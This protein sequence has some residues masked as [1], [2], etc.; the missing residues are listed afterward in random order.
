MDYDKFA[1][2]IK[3][4][5]NA[6]LGEDYAP[7]G[8]DTCGYNSETVRSMSSEDFAQ[9]LRDIDQLTAEFKAAK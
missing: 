5:L 7:G 8:C 2:E 9:L 1:E 6:R 4:L 3:D